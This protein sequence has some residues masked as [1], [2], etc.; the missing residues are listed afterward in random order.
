M[1]KLVRNIKTARAFTCSCRYSDSTQTKTAEQQNIKTPDQSKNLKVQT[2]DKSEEIAKVV[3][4]VL[5]TKEDMQWRTPWHQKDGQYYNHLRA[6]YSAESNR[7]LLQMLQAPI[8][9]SPSAIKAW[10]QRKKKEKDIIMQGYIPE[11]NQT[12]GNELAAAHFTVYRGGAVKFVGENRWIK[13]NVL[14]EYTL[15]G[16][17]DGSKVLEAIDCENMTL[18]YEGLVNYRNLKQVEWLSLKGCENIDDWCLDRISW[19]FRDTL[20]YLDLRECQNYT[21]RGLGALYKM[22]CLKI[23]Y[24]DDITLNDS[25]ELTCL[26]LQELNPDL[27]IRTD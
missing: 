9:F 8:D 19:T 16:H 21:H 5:P 6:F 20:V 27:D 7:G 15:P 24:V 3:K 14:G 4:A 11:R 26:M 23:L 25:F 22:N 1:F 2:T 18:Y 13:Q 12:L 10:W 17:Y